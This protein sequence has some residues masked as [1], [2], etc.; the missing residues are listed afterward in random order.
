MENARELRKRARRH[1]QLADHILTETYPLVKD[2]KL[3]LAVVE[4][5]F[6][7]LEGF[8]YAAIR[9]SVA[10]KIKG[11]PKKSKTQLTGWNDLPFD[12]IKKNFE[13]LVAPSLGISRQEVD[14]A[15]RLKT[16]VDLH[17]G[18]D[19]E[20]ARKDAFV[21]CGKSYD[22]HK[23]SYMEVKVWLR[24]AKKIADAVEVS[25]LRIDE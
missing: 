15:A 5:M 22:P 9:G 18:C 7:A 17:K 20:F 2:E 10:Q 14:L 16:L 8:M 19:V 1:L 24:S 23:I 13:E 12:D 3:L 6:L 21:I 4:N 25:G 11:K